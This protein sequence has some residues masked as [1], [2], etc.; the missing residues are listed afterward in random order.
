MLKLDGSITRGLQA[1][2][3]AFVLPMPASLRS[4]RC[5]V[6][7]Q[8]QT[9]DATARSDQGT[10]WVY[11]TVCAGL[12]ATHAAEEDASNGACLA[13]WLPEICKT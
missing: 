2:S 5:N 6:G 3:N 7:L 8:Y 9:S 1:R 11:S 13:L 4:R 10:Y 12:F